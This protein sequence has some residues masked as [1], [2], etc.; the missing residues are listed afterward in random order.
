MTYQIA[1][2]SKRYFTDKQHYL[3]FR[4]AWSEAVN[5]DSAK[6]S[7]DETYGTR[8]P[9]WLTSAHMLLYALLRGRDIRTAFTPLT[10]ERKL[11]GSHPDRG[12]RDAY[13]SLKRLSN[14]YMPDT[15][16]EKFLAPFNETVDKETLL[17]VI[18]ELSDLE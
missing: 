6:P 5:S 17:S 18:E 11:Q 9:G 2:A 7:K 16:V 14:K 12:M 10:A 13:H 1:D 15:Y 8:I 3:N 4:T